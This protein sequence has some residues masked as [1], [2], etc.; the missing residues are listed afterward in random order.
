[1][2]TK[3]PLPPP[4]PATFTLWLLR[5]NKNDLFLKLDNQNNKTTAFCLTKQS[6]HL[7]LIY[8]DFKINGMQ[9]EI[10]THTFQTFKG[11]RS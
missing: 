5:E 11:D 6:K 9:P 7:H 10:F 8:R 3:I 2:W 4:L 1:M